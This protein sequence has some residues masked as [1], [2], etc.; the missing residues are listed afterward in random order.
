MAQRSGEKQQSA[1][2]LVCLHGKTLHL[3]KCPRVCG[4]VR[5]A[6]AEAGPRSEDCPPV[7]KPPD[8]LLLIP[9]GQR[10]RTGKQRRCRCGQLGVSA[11]ASPGSC[12]P[13]P[14]T[15]GKPSRSAAHSAAVV[16]PE[17]GLGSAQPSI[18]SG[19]FAVCFPG[20]TPKRF[21]FLG[22]LLQAVISEWGGGR[23]PSACREGF[24]GRWLHGG[25]VGNNSLLERKLD[26][27]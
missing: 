26:P 2:K 13:C 25:R 16:Q 19:C 18:S 5:G 21:L 23:S 24:A 14:G 22:G 12:L 1:E 3:L 7:T 17:P 20:Q 15:S 11:A 4:S 10:R 27:V 8:P 6:P 9:L